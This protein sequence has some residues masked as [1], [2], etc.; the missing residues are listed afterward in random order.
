MKERLKKLR[1]SL[2]LTQQ[3]F[4]DRIGVKRATIACY[5]TGVNEPIDAIFTS[6]CKEYGVSEEWLR[7]GEG[8]MFSKELYDELDKLV[9][10]HHLNDKAGEMIRKFV[11][12]PPDERDVIINYIESVVKSILE[13]EQT[14]QEAAAEL[15][16][17]EI[18]KLGEEYMDQLRLEKRQAEESSASDDAS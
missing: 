5:E 14:Q 18:K 9:E 11:E 4:A 8:E 6:I 17:E 16:E 3:Q 10:K 13:K 15:T 1:T 7:T 12:L 2:G